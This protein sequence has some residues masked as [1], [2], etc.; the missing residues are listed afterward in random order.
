MD[1]FERTKHR[2]EV[3]QAI[4]KRPKYHDRLF[5]LGKD[6]AY[7]ADREENDPFEKVCRG[8]A[9]GEFQ[10]RSWPFDDDDIVWVTHTVHWDLYH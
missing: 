9:I 1:Y 3:A 4:L 7:A 5:E 6:N 8:Y 10:K 2:F